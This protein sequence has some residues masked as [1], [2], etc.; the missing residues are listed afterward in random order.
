MLVEPLI[1]DRTTI[2]ASTPTVMPRVEIIETKE[3]IWL[4]LRV[5]VYRRPMKSETGLNMTL[6]YPLHGL[7]TDESDGII[8]GAGEALQGMRDQYLPRTVKGPSRYLK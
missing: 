3:I 4:F 1:T 6:Q 2:S 7:E 5:R 8:T